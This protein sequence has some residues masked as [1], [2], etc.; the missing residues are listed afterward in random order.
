MTTCLEPNYKQQR[1]SHTQKS[2]SKNIK[3]IKKKLKTNL[4]FPHQKPSPF[5]LYNQP[6]SKNYAYNPHT[7][8]DLEKKQ[9]T[10]NTNQHNRA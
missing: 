5:H 7:P 1:I 10:H 2:K 3:I 6:K 9:E 8:I 4:N